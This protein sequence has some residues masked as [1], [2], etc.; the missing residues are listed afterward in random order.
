MGRRKRSFSWSS[1]TT[2]K[3]VQEAKNV[4]C[5][6][7]GL[8][9]A[10]RSAAYRSYKL[11]CGCVKDI[12]TGS[13]RAG[14]VF[15]KKCD[16]D[17]R[18]NIEQL[19]WSAPSTI[20]HAAEAATFGFTLVGVGDNFST[21]SYKAPCGHVVV[22]HTAHMRKGKAACMKCRKKDTLMRYAKKAEKQGCLLLGAGN[23][24]ITHSYKLPCGHVR[25]LQV[26]AFDSDVRCVICEETYASQ[27]SFL[28]LLK[29][30]SGTFT[31]VKCGY[32][33]NLEV[34]V[35]QY[36]LPTGTEI[37]TVAKIKVETGAVAKK[38][39][40]QLHSKFNGYRIASEDMKAFHTKG[41]HTECYPV[42]VL[43]R[44]TKDLRRLA[45]VVS[46]DL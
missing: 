22:T 11:P 12:Q 36:G 24:P 20:K 35:Q 30:R 31:W 38:V 44:L 6:L 40:K 16:T 42:S 3:H 15:C 4:G 37:E 43:P 28:Y 34:R 25:E 41:G 27:P 7:L 39:E 19:D 18:S 45:P 17:K 29:M 2:K 13:V 46:S 9:I 5:I 8:A 10:N 1:K 21:R 14:V 26:K 33:K 32:S 23:T